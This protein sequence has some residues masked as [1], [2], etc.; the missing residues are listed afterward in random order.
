MAFIYFF[1]AVSSMLETTNLDAS[2]SHL[3]LVTFNRDNIVINVA[4]MLIVLAILYKLLK[5][6]IDRLNPKVLIVVL[7]VYT[8]ALSLVWIFSAK[9]V[10]QYDSYYITETAKQVANGEISM[11]TTGSDRYFYYYPYQLGFVAV[12]QVF[13][14]IFK[15]DTAYYYSLQILNALAL[16]LLYLAILKLTWDIFKSKAVLNITILLTFGY[17]PMLMFTSFIYGNILGFALAMWSVSLT[18]RYIQTDRPYLMLIASVLLGLSVM[19]KNNNLIVL[20]A[21]SIILL[22]K[23]LDTRKVYD[24]I[25][26]GLCVVLSINVLNIA[27]GYYEDRAD[28]NFGGG[29]P[30]LLYLDMGLHESEICYGWYDPTY[31]LVVY[32]NSGLDSKVATEEGIKQIKER[33]DYFRENPKYAN[34]FFNGKIL[35]QW[36]EPSYA[37]VWVN[38]ARKTNGQPAQYVTDIYTGTLGN[39]LYEYMNQYQQLLFI[40]S[41]VAFVSIAKK[42]DVTYY[43]LPLIVLGGFLFHMLFEAKS[44]YVITYVTLLIPMCAYGLYQYMQSNVV[45]KLKSG[46]SQISST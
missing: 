13:A 6:H 35:S 5:P 10:P 42:K 28:V 34:E 7:C 31:T 1:L 21:I 23:F 20:V 25:S 4:I 3:E 39:Y 14:S 22:I 44:Q 38:E 9:T 16:V 19:V 43:I 12:C 11:L 15:G 8:F 30:K 29:V 26:I 17:I 24:I 41:C 27:I 32:A 46:I 45:A 18:V 2:G 40:M 36:N 37:S 33:L